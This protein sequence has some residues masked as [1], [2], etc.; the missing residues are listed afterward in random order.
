MDAASGLIE[1]YNGFEA[2]P[3]QVTGNQVVW[4]EALPIR[5]PD[6]LHFQQELMPELA[7]EVPYYDSIQAMCAV[8]TNGRIQSVTVLPGD[9]TFAPDRR[10]GGPEGDA[11]EHM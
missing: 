1:R 8:V 10:C 6:G 9:R 11:P 4:T 2:G 5:T 3:R 7:A